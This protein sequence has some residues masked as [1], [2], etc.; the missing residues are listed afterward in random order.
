MI[1]DMYFQFFPTGVTPS[2]RDSQAIHN[3][4]NAGFPLEQLALELF[5][6]G[7]DYF[8][9]VVANNVGPTGFVGGLYRDVLGRGFSILEATFW[10]NQLGAGNLNR[11]QIASLFL[12]SAERRAQLINGYYQ[13]FLGRNADA[14]AMNFWQNVLAAGG[15]AENI[16]AGILSSPEFFITRGGDS[17]TFIR[18]LYSELLQ[19]SVS[20]SQQE[21]DF[22][23]SQ[24]AMSNR[25][26]IQ[27]RADVVLS[28]AASDEFR[29]LLIN[30][31]FQLYLGRSATPNERFNLLQ[32]L[33]TGATHEAAQITILLNR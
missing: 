2:S 33:R 11:Q 1:N 10:T 32:L 20:P 29:S 22:W 7:G 14:G 28:F 30:D 3:D 5:K 21:L 4:L 18:A 27:A 8:N 6:S 23:I 15:R 13:D 17:D 26:E 16:L 31:W 25:G 19:R 12:N 24:L 9:H